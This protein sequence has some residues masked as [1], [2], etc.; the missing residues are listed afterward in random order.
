LAI[1]LTACVGLLVVGCSP[2]PVAPPASLAPVARAQRERPSSAS[3]PQSDVQH[4]FELLVSIGEDVGA[5]LN[6][7]SDGGIDGP[8]S[9]IT[10]PTALRE[11][12][13]RLEAAT[14]TANELATELDR[15]KNERS[16]H[17]R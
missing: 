15:I 4:V 6:S 13:S 1:R 17:G 5:I 12:D 2:Q 16:E 3:S 8:K 11:A 14:R 7:F 10:N 9:P